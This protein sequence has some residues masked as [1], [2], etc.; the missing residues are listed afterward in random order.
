LNGLFLFNKN[1]LSPTHQSAYRRHYS[2]ET[3]LLSICNN[4]ILAADQGMVTLVVLPLDTQYCWTS[5]KLDLQLLMLCSTGTK[6]ILL[7]DHT[8]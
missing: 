4:A 1:H 3:A 5:S 8:I 7:N 2:T 6:L